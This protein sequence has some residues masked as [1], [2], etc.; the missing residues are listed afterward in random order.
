MKVGLLWY[1]D[2]PGRA[3]EEKVLEAAA[4]YQQKY[5]VPPNLCL[6][7]P[8]AFDGREPP[9][10]AGGVEIRPGN[11]ILPHHFWIGVGEPR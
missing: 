11:S 8:S 6:V 4:R 7:H 3:L 5:G 9:C 2:D 1:D 10:R